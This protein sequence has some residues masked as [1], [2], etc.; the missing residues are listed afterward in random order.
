MNKFFLLAFS[1]LLP[2]LLRADNP[3]IGLGSWREHIPTTRPLPSPT[4]AT[5]CIAPASSD[6]SGY[7]KDDGEISYFTRLG[8]LSDHEIKTIRYETQRGIPVIAYENSNIDLLFADKTIVNLGDIKRK[9][10]VGGKAINHI[11]FI[12]G[13]AYLSCQFGIVVINLDRRALEDT[14]HR[15]ERRQPERAGTRVR[16]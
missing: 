1:S 5:G 6:C 12:N 4:R 14:Y 13:K 10:I 9:N 16:R 8:G 7:K 15:T 3:P 11:L 2:L